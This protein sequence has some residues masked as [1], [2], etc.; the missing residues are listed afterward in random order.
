MLDCWQKQRTHRPSFASVV[1]TLDNLARQPQTLLTTRNSP[2]NDSTQMMEV[3]RGHNVFIST[4]MWL[5]SIKMSRYS[6]HF[7]DANLVT[8]QQVTTSFTAAVAV[9]LG[10]NLIYISVLYVQISRLTAQQLSDMG[11]TLVGHQ[12][13]ILHQARQ[14][15]TII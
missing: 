1:T 2:D 7:K 15:D 11:I 9:S 8:A 4:D 5:E 6:Q 12:K 10:L 3:P 13:K 14:L